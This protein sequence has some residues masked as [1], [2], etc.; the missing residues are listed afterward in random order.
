MLLAA[1]PICLSNSFPILI[2]MRV[3]QPASVCLETVAN[4]YSPEERGAISGRSLG[5][6]RRL[7]LAHWRG[8]I[9]S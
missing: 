1:V 2:T 3:G 5:H 8:V 4:S 7:R 6:I 9:Q